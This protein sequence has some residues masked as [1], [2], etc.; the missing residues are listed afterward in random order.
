MAKIAPLLFDPAI[1]KW[2]SIK[3]NTHHYFKFTPR[4]IRIT[5]TLMF[6]VPFGF[7]YLFKTTDYQY[8]MRG[9]LRGDALKK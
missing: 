3:E 7:Y 6:G 2:Y 8:K 5:A 4:V 9:A 1:E